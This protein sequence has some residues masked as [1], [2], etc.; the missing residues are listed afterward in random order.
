MKWISLYDRL[1]KLPMAITNHKHIYAVIDKGDGTGLKEIPLTL[2]FDKKGH[3]YFAEEVNKH[4][5]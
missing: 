1:G 4:T 2:K 3:P 5:D